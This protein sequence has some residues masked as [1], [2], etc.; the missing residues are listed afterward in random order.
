L[1]GGSIRVESCIKKLVDNLV[2]G[3][4]LQLPRF[5]SIRYS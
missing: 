5:D 2:L 1:R 4:L 3:S